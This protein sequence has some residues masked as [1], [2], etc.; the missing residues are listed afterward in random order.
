[1][2][3]V[4]L[5][6]CVF[7]LSIVFPTFAE[8]ETGSANIDNLLNSAA[9]NYKAKKYAK[10]LEDLD[11]AKREIT[12]LHFQVLKGFL[13]KTIPGYETEEMDSGAV[14]GIQNVSRKY[15]KGEQDIEISVSSG[16][17][18][19]GG[20]GLGALMGMASAFQS[21]DAGTQSQMI[22]VKDRKGRFNLVESDKEGTL[23]FTLQN[24]VV[25]MVKTHGFP[26]SDEAKKTAELIDFDGIEKA[27]Q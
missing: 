12:N 16:N 3:K 24:N 9:Q 14:F 4:I 23:T 18:G 21:M 6:V 10:A 2:K 22:V 5:F 7:A 13:P 20:T 26:N 27:Y 17:L 15:N 8:N 19:E 11:W 1:M 25:L